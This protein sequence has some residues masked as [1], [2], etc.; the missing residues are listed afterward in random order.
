LT[1]YIKGTDALENEGLPIFD[2]KRNF[3]RN[4]LS[5]LDQP[6]SRNGRLLVH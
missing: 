2:K 4:K 5:R 1:P 6:L 3:C